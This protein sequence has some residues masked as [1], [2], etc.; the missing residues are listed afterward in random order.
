MGRCICHLPNG[1]FLEWSSV[2]DAPVTYGMPRAQF[3]SYMREEHGR[4]YFENDHPRLMARAVKYGTSSRIHP[5][6]EDLVSFNRAGPKESCLTLDEILSRY[7]QVP[8]SS[9]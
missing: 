8:Q 7:G 3:D 9:A 1:N 5:S 4:H 6:L 2:V